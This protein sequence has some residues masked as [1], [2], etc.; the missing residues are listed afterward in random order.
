MPTQYPKISEEL[1]V[2]RL[3]PPTG[4]VNMV[5]DTDTYNEIDDQFAIVYTMLSQDKIN[6]QAI[7]AAPFLNR[8]SES[9][10]DGMDK[11]YDEIIRIL[12]RMNV[13]ADGFAFRGSER[14]MPSPGEPEDSPA[15]RDLIA[16]AL[17]APADEPLYV[18]AIGAITNVASAIALEPRIIEK[19]VVVW[20]GG[21]RLDWQHTKEF[22]LKQDVC[23]A[24]IVLDSGVP[25][26]LV[27][28]SGVASH[29]ITTLPEVERYVKG[30]GAI[31][32]FL[33]ERYEACSSD[34]YG[35]SRVI[36]DISVIAW[37]INPA[38]VPSALVHS[39]VLTDQIT[40]SRDTSRH[41]IRCAHYVQRDAIF[42]DLFRKLEQHALAAS[43]TV[44]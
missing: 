31:G 42:K 24:R 2:R 1:R 43:E 38:S 33:A 10:K 40:W 13:P 36:W 25:L 34:H 26:V 39:P 6:L 32:D 22:N 5:L 16:R 17:A 3:Q 18:V 37:L 21:H 11:S 14:F 8:L 15:A 7:Y 12:R 23:A 28:C 20:L 29:L 4:Q 41:L 30:Q 44:R 35:Y 9:A 27:P 19:I